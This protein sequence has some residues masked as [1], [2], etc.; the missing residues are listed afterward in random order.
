[1]NIVPKKELFVDRY[2]G[3]VEGRE[4]TKERFGSSAAY[5]LKELNR[6]LP[7]G[8]ALVQIPGCFELLYIRRCCCG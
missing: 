5:M 1:M 8:S 2:P 7:R 3:A 6:N 4:K